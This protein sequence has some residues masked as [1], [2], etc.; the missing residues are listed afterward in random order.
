MSQSLRG[1]H[2]SSL[3]G[4]LTGYDI[5]LIRACYK[6]KALRKPIMHD[7]LSNVD[8]M[9]S[10]RPEAES[11]LVVGVQCMFLWVSEIRILLDP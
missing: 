4:Y 9:V 5:K 8:L 10:Y 11:H 7:V 3:S 1:K 6:L 2:E